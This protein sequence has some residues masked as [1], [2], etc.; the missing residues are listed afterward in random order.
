MKYRTR[1]IYIYKG[2]YDFEQKFLWFSLLFCIK[3]HN[4]VSYLPTLVVT[5]VLSALMTISVYRIRERVTSVWLHFRPTKFHTQMKNA[6][7][8]ARKYFCASIMWPICGALPIKQEPKMSNAT[9]HVDGKLL[10]NQ[11]LSLLQCTCGMSGE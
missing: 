4:L 2:I 8:V 5:W 11:C 3:V 10:F 9:K 7:V 6:Y 1:S